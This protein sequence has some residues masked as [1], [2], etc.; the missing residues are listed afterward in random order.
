MLL[1]VI[2]GDSEQVLILP[3]T[4]H[5][6]ITWMQNGG[7]MSKLIVDVQTVDPNSKVILLGRITQSKRE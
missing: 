6:L 1:C 7:V 4:F 2:Y 3:R 5:R